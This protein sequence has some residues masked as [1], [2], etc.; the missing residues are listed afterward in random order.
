MADPIGFEIGASDDHTQAKL[1]N[2]FCRGLKNSINDKFLLSGQMCHIV[3]K[4]N[5]K[6]EN[7]IIEL[8][9]FIK[10]KQE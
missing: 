5:T 2:G 6:S 1:L 10:A 9:E 8:A 7:I 4:L 3:E